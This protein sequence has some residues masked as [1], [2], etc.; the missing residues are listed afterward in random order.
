MTCG[1]TIEGGPILAGTSADSATKQAFS[2]GAIRVSRVCLRFRSPD[3]GPAPYPIGSPTIVAQPMRQTASA[4]RTKL[5]RFSVALEGD[6]HPDVS[7]MC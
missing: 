2:F 6:R 7:I 3:Y 5:L 1:F 4:A